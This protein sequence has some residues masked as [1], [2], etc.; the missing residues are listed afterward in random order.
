MNTNLSKIAKVIRI[1]FCKFSRFHKKSLQ[2]DVR[3]VPSID[4]KK[5]TVNHF[6]K[7]FFDFLI[8]NFVFQKNN[9]WFY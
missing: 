9:N 2:T 7:T 6:C 5:S 1:Q 4:I 3:I 8:V